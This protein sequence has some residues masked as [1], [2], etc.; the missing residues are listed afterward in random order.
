[1]AKPS[2]ND[3][4]TRK[5]RTAE[6]P[7]QRTLTTRQAEYFADRAGIDAD[8][9]VG[10]K[11]AE[12]AKKLEW[13]I[14]PSL[15]FYQQ[16]CGRVVKT[17]PVTG[18]KRGVPFATVHVE[19][20]DCSFLGFFPVEHPYYW[21]LYPVSCHRETI[22]TVT[23]DACGNFCVNIPR[24]DIDRILR[25]RKHRVCFPDIVKPRLPDLVERIPGFGP[26]D[27]DPIDPPPYELLLGTR[28]GSPAPGLR[29]FGEPTVPDVIPPLGRITPPLS[30]DALE[31]ARPSLPQRKEFPS[32]RHPIGPFLRCR[33][34]WV[35]EWEPFF[36]VPDITFRVTQD[37]D[38][39]GT[40]ETIY[41]EGFF[42][43]R[44]NDTNIGTVELEASPIAKA[45]IGCDAPG[46]PCTDVPA[47]IE[48]GRMPTA[49]EY[50]DAAGYARRVNRPRPA[51]TPPTD[52][53]SPF[54]GELQLTGC[55]DSVDGVQYFRVLDEHGGTEQPITGVSWTSASPAPPGYVVMTPDADGWYPVAVAAT[56]ANPHLVMS[57]PVK[58]RAQGSHTL[59]LELA[60]GA[61]AHLAFST[62]LPVVIDDRNPDSTLLSVKYRVKGGGVAWADAAELVGITCPVIPRTVGTDI[63][64]RVSWAAGDDHFRD[65]ELRAHG[66]GGGSGPVHVSGSG[67][68]AT[69]TLPGL[70]QRWYGAPAETGLVRTDVFEIG[71]ASPQ[72]AYGVQ[73]TTYGRSFT[74]AGVAGP[75]LDWEIDRSDRWSRT[76]LRFAV[77]DS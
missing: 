17:D 70:V 59:R 18:E 23:T 58:D 41:A 61:K 56:Q 21:W 52:A 46:V 32:L 2:E 50:L 48:I 74:P 39:D 40:E 4:S 13:Y 25:F 28:P 49:A 34:V 60:D 51:T 47:I 8:D 14:D 72:G 69:V 35:A 63:E 68:P 6:D 76:S 5:R 64:L 22:T 66:C 75:T 53:E 15:W 7:R 77:I 54:T 43:V 9:L 24:W 27:P 26:G 16:V 38:G 44:W 62:P 55:Y 45:A 67:D 31:R 71:A 3:T 57:W 36:D 12:V 37:V 29:R 19:D 11:V 1:M 42:D 10:V 73:V 65:T 33:D 30:A 20:T